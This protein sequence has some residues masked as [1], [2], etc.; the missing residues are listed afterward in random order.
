MATLKNKK[1]SDKIQLCNHKATWHYATLCWRGLICTDVNFKIILLAV[2]PL[3][4]CYPW[5]QQSTLAS[6]V[7]QDQNLDEI[8]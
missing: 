6:K 4:S 1:H 3:L 5:L 2:P 7:L 8:I